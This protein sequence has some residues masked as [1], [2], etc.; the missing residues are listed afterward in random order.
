MM[1][2][3]YCT[4]SIK[5]ATLFPD[6]RTV[7]PGH[8]HDGKWH[9]ILVQYI[10]KTLLIYIDGAH[11]KGEKGV[12]D[13]AIPAGALIKLAHRKDSNDVNYKGLLDR[14]NI[15]SYGIGNGMAN[16]MSRGCGQIYHG[17]VI[18]WEQFKYGIRNNTKVIPST[19]PMQKGM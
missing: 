15:W 2:T 13:L 17:D 3:I 9:H 8:L 6:Y 10:T 12:D 7:V 5:Q 19:C 14:F 18:S 16:I 1:T 11:Y 4:L